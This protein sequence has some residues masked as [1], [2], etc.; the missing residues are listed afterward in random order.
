M[1]IP[2]V[3]QFCIYLIT[4]PRESILL[5][6]VAYNSSA[7]RQRLYLY[8]LLCA[9]KDVEKIEREELTYVN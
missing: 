7:C 4:F 3:L 6:F 9:T 5:N 2:F 8:V 1:D